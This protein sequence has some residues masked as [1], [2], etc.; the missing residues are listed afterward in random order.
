M[1]EASLYNIVT[2]KNIDNE[3]FP[4]RYNTSD[5]INAYYYDLQPGEV[6]HLPTFIAN[7]AVKHLIDRMLNKQKKRI[8]NEDERAALT[9]RIVLNIE[10]TEM[11]RPKSK[12]QMAIEEAERRRGPSD[13]DKYLSKGRGE[14]TPEPVTRVP[15]VA[16]VNTTPLPTPPAEN[17]TQEDFNN[18]DNLPEDTDEEAPSVAK[19]DPQNPAT[20]PTQ[21]VITDS[22]P[23]DA[24]NMPSREALYGYAKSNLG[25]VLDEKQTKIL[26]AKSVEELVTELDYPVSTEQ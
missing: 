14:T 4:I 15:R 9:S 19:A 7:L 13:L 18:P 24:P 26:D 3:M 8:N 21:P 2:I 22:V 6:K 16:P 5:P 20:D 23:T 1:E 10:K 25:M 12:E 11:T 17:G